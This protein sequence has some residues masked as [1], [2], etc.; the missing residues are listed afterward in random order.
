MLFVIIVAAYEPFLFSNKMQT[1]LLSIAVIV[2]IW[3]VILIAM[4]LK[5]EVYFECI[6]LMGRCNIVLTLTL[7]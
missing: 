6:Q 5:S 2:L 7:M 3:W 1:Q 4:S